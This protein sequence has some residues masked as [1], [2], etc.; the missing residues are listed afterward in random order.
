MW[1]R[2][3]RIYLL[4][5]TEP[6]IEPRF[7]PWVEKI[8]ITSRSVSHWSERKNIPSIMIRGSAYVYISLMKHKISSKILWKDLKQSIGGLSSWRAEKPCRIRKNL[9]RSSCPLQLTHTHCILKQMKNRSQGT[10]ITK[11]ATHSKK[12]GNFS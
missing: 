10:P 4:C 1:L 11:N 2:W 5:G 6:R 7:D 9:E 8:I 3:S 12:T